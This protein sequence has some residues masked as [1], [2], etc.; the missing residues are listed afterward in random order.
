MYAYIGQ[1]VE[2]RCETHQASKFTRIQHHQENGTIETLLSN[3]YLNNEYKN[4]EI[5]IKKV[6]FFYIVVIQPVRI[7]SGG[8][9]TCEDDVSLM[10]KTNHIANITLHVIGK[11]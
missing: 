8:R 9:Y 6:G 11:L 2:L 10:N 7:H 3:D 1:S 5:H 4:S